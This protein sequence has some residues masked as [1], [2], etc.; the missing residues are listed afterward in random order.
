MSSQLK[1]NYQDLSVRH[2]VD[3]RDIPICKSCGRHIQEYMMGQCSCS[4]EEFMSGPIMPPTWMTEADLEELFQQFEL[5]QKGLAKWQL[6]E[7]RN[8]EVR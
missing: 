5:E 1:E 8:A 6:K 3:Y 4:D 7:N 2:T